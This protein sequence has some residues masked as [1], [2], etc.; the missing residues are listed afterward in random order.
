MLSSILNSLLGKFDIV[1]IYDIIY[2]L[3]MDADGN[4]QVIS[5]I[6]KVMSTLG[7]IDL[8]RSNPVCHWYVEIMSFCS[9]NSQELCNE[10]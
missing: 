4:S 8:C 9:V 7:Q 5:M 3:L 2:S 6:L 1:L 10:H